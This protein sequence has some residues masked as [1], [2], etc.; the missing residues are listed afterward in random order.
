MRGLLLAVAPLILG[1]PS[2]DAA[3]LRVDVTAAPGPGAAPT[4]ATVLFS[5][6]SKEQSPRRVEVAVPGSAIADLPAATAWEVSAAAEGFVSPIQRIDARPDLALAVRLVAAT[7]IRGR[8]K[9]PSGHPVARAVSVRVTSPGWPEQH[10]DQAFLAECPV[11]GAS[12]ACPVPSGE[13]DL[14]LR[15]ARLVPVYK[16]GLKLVAGGQV[17]LGLVD[18]QE[19]ASL[20]G[21][22]ETDDGSEVP[23]SARVEVI[24]QW[25]GGGS[26]PSFKGARAMR[27]QT[28]PSPLG[29]FQV[30]GLAT[31]QYEVAVDAPGFARAKIADVVVQADLEAQLRDPIVLGRPVRLSVDIEPSRAPSG[32]TWSVKLIAAPPGVA[33]Y[34]GPVSSEGLWV[35]D[36]VAP[37]PYVLMVIDAAGSRWSREEAFVDGNRN[38]I[39]VHMPLVRVQGDVRRG[40]DA[41]SGVLW[42]GGLN[43]RRRI[44][45]E[46]NAEGRFAGSLPEE[47]S[48]TVVLVDEAGFRTTLKPV[49]VRLAAGQ[50]A[51]ELSL[52]LPD[53]KLA[54][55]VVDARGRPVAGATVKLVHLGGQET[56]AASQA[57]PAGAPS[58]GPAARP[59][60]GDE[61]VTGAD[62][63]FQARGLEAGGW[64]IRAQEEERVSDSVLSTVQ[65]GFEP[66][67]VTLTLADTRAVKGTVRARSGPVAGAFVG[68]WG[69]PGPSAV[70]FGQMA[71]AR[72]DQTGRFSL[73][74]P[75]PLA[76]R[77][78]A[79]MVVSAPGHATRLL[80]V[81]FDLERI[82]VEVQAEGGTLV[83]LKPGDRAAGQASPI[84]MHDGAF[85]LPG[86]LASLEPQAG[87][88]SDLMLA[89]MEPGLYRLCAGRAAMT[90]IKTQTAPDPSG[91]VSG[92]VTVQGRVVLDPAPLY[93][94]SA[95]A[96]R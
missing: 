42:F 18:M 47:G 62:G 22:I 13:H 35:Q 96:S 61:V 64:M 33:E 41:V 23:S 70:S 72:S 21:R 82:D 80:R 69:D 79:N 86:V 29:I 52:R 89:N 75:A 6:L 56:A 26:L 25:R 32:G 65:E 1:A 5:P 58:D 90:A 38:S 40:R 73:S 2:V 87:G 92:S 50:E 30:A 45:I 9:L 95:G 88:Q 17:D 67:S 63:Q 3:S 31:G 78:V 81:A 59:R 4:R 76:E 66:A 53:T 85:A 55:Q 60:V 94:T 77:G 49:D 14:R 7:T 48:W 93:P 20:I 44:R 16:W 83:I 84:L 51:A 46:C 27:H 68:I 36:G 12:W 57:G 34:A 71:I 37:G 24:P 74:V 28:R 10:P 43:G 8:L 15:V 39:R 11:K 91:C 54:G 19:G